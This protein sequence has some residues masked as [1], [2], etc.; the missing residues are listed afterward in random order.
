MNLYERAR[1]DRLKYLADSV[2]RILYK[3]IK[4]VNNEA[5]QA[6]LKIES[7][8]NNILCQKRNLLHTLC[9]FNYTNNSTQSSHMDVF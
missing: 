6:Q 5:R 1:R 4:A 3:V 8:F 7:S 9:D 2:T